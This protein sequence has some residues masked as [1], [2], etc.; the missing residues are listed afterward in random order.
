MAKRQEDLRSDL[1]RILRGLY[2]E[3]AD[4]DPSAAAELVEQIHKTQKRL[5]SFEEVE[6]I[7]PQADISKLQVVPMVLHF[8]PACGERIV[9]GQ[10]V[11]TYGQVRLCNYRCLRNYLFPVADDGN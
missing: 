5:Q 3:L 8:C 1:R 4:T 10:K 7:G 9:Q 2:L 6:P 11:V